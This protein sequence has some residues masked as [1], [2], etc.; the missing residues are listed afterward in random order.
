MFCYQVGCTLVTYMIKCG[1]PISNA[2]SHRFDEPGLK[3]K[4]R[5][6]SYEELDCSIN[7]QYHV[8]CRREGKEVFLP[9]SFLE[10]YYDVY[11]KIATNSKGREHFEWSHSY[12]RV[13]KPATKYD[14]S[15]IFMYFD[16]Y[17]VEIRER[18]KCVSAL[19]GLYWNK[20][21]VFL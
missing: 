17:N 4:G 21:F 3:H 11:G 5:Y 12:S 10:K 9:F 13:Y 18:V 14:S 7:G 16:K 19:E 20:R 6:R 8:S 15:G 2:S 1:H